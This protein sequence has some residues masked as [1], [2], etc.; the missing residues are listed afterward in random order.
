MC[1]VVVPILTCLNTQFDAW[2][3]EA[4]AHFLYVT[5]THRLAMQLQHKTM[6]TNVNILI[7]TPGTAKN[8]TSHKHPRGAGQRGSFSQ[9]TLTGVWSH[10]V[11]PWKWSPGGRWGVWRARRGLGVEDVYKQERKQWCTAVCFLLHR[12]ICSFKGRE[13]GGDHRALFVNVKCCHV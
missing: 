7:F 11:H 8:R 6:H 12:I 10:H 2:R 9:V 5:C 3:T 4:Y 13:E 1:A